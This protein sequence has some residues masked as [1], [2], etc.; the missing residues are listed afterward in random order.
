MKSTK[1]LGPMVFID[2]F[3]RSFFIQAVWNYQSMISIGFCFA[4]APVAKKTI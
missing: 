4:L 2:I 3:F 1:K